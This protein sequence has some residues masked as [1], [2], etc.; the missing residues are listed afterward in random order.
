LLLCTCVSAQV[1]AQDCDCA[2]PV[3]FVHGWAGSEY[4]W[5]N[6]AGEMAATWG[7]DLMISGEDGVPTTEGTVYFANL[8]WQYGQTNI[9]GANNTPNGQSSYI[10]DDVI[11]HEQFASAPTLLPNKCLYAI[12]FATRRDTLSGSPDLI[13]ESSSRWDL[14]APRMGESSSSE[15]A[16]F[17]QGYALGKA[18]AAIRV[19][20][21]KDKVILVAHSMGGLA[22]REY[23]QRKV[24]NQHPWWVEPGS[25][26]GHKVAKLLTVGSPHRGANSGNSIA[27]SSFFAQKFEEAGMNLRSE[28]VR[29]LRYFYNVGDI[30]NGTLKNSAYQYG[31]AEGLIVN[32]EP[33][34]NKDVNCNGTILES[35]E[36]INESGLS[37]GLSEP[38]L[39]TRDNPVLALPTDLKYT[40]YVSDKVRLLEAMVR[41]RLGQKVA[42]IG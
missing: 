35:I 21:G 23:L 16:P 38:W 40:Y 31:N 33:F 39:G 32:D 19:A 17:K 8:N 34:Y 20:S 24:G 14:S 42:K 2:Y 36:G 37:I 41:C 22:S 6:M 27:G 5:D 29:D 30:G 12:S 28:A 13:R 26:D 4:S 25:A 18:I 9:W 1:V 11:L 10:D 7:D 15:S 3:V